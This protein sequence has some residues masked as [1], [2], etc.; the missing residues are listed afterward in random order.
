TA[1]QLG[2]ANRVKIL[3][4]ITDSEKYWLLKNCAAFCFPSLAEGFGLPVIE[5]MQFGTPVILSTAT[6]LPEIGGPHALY[7]RDFSPESI[8]QTSADFLNT[9]ITPEMKARIIDWSMQFRW[10]I[11]AKKYWE[12]YRY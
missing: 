8:S 6:S 5:A 4:A 2:V 12:L 7:L 3:G 9:T 1:Q 11:A 10:D